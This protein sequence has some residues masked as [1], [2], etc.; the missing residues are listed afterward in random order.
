MSESTVQSIIKRQRAKLGLTQSELAA[1]VGVTEATISRWESGQISNMR[2][3][4]IAALAR[5]LEISPSALI[6]GGFESSESIQRNSPKDDL[7]EFYVPP[8]LQPDQQELLLSFERL[9]KESRDAIF[10]LVRLLRD[11]EHVSIE[12]RV[13]EVIQYFCPV[14]YNEPFFLDSERVHITKMRAKPD[15]PVLRYMLQVRYTDEEGHLFEEGDILLFSEETTLIDKE[16]YF[17]TYDGIGHLA[18]AYKGCLGTTEIP[19]TAM[20][21]NE[22]T[23]GVFEVVDP[24]LKIYGRFVGTMNPNNG[25]ISFLGSKKA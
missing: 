24:K 21:G 12:P 3:S 19:F 6:D 20:G 1:K 23:N 8:Y 14:Y 18:R 22:I 17:I 2:R 15:W 10:S 4:K 5:A 16:L 25:G 9:S 13:D 11:R 7:Y